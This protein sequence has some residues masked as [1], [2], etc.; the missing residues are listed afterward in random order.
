[1]ILNSKQTVVIYRCPTCGTHVVSVVGIFTLSGDLI[2]LKCKCGGSEMTVAY[3]RDGR[4]RL[5]IP[6]TV[7]P[8]DH[9]YNLTSQS[10]FD[11]DLIKLTCPFMAIDIAFIGEKKAALKAAEE[12]DEELLKMLSENGIDDLDQLRGEDTA[13]EGG[14]YDSGSTLYDIARFLLCE[15][16]D[17]DEIKC[18]C[19][20][21]EGDYDFELVGD[22]D[23]SVRFFCKSC[24]ASAVYPISELFLS[25]GTIKIDT[26]YLL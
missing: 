1:M 13:G 5:S 25:D 18:R 3:T 21:G 14:L 10:F 19:K 20:N 12:S 8:N 11:A 16:F 7:C 9:I 2:K 15:L 22:E 24:G 6:C 17:E 23:D 4:I 26:L